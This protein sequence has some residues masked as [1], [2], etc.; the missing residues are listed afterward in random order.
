VFNGCAH[1]NEY[2]E[3][4]PNILPSLFDILVRFRFHL[5]APVA[6]I[7]KAFHMISIKEEDQDALRY[8]WLKS[9]DQGLKEIVV[10][11]FCRLVLGLKP[12]PAILGVVFRTVRN[13][14]LKLLKCWKMIYM[15][16]I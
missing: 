14:N 6:D 5:Y 8:L 7:E 4:G 2:L 10:Y 11:R 16:T 3:R 13:L 12:S 9:V 1:Y 15:L